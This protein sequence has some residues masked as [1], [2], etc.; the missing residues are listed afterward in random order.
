MDGSVGWVERSEPHQIEESLALVGLAPLDPPYRC[1]RNRCFGNG[2]FRN[3]RLRNQD[4]FAFHGV[5]IRL[6]RF[7][8]PS[9]GMGSSSVAIR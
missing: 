5:R 1:F 6:A 2:C 8:A 4:Y 7:R 3:R 9:G